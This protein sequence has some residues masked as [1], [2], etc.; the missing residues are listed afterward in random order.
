MSHLLSSLVESLQVF[1]IMKIRYKLGS[2]CFVLGNFYTSNFK[3]SLISSL[4]DISKKY[5]NTQAITS[6]KQ[7]AHSRTSVSDVTYNNK[8]RKDDRWAAI[9]FVNLTLTSIVKAV[10]KVYSKFLAIFHSSFFKKRIFF[11]FCLFVCLLINDRS[12][13]MIIYYKN[14]SSQTKFDF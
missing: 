9:G 1:I 7:W 2:L 8:M 12:I 6:V 5:F 11:F 10:R 3:F 4:F 14:P 13:C